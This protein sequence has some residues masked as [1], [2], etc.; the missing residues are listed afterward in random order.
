[1]PVVL[2]FMTRMII[3][4]RPMCFC[5]EALIGVFMCMLAEQ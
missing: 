5:V 2:R 1:M 4:V 3:I